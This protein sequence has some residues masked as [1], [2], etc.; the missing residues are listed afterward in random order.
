MGD[1]EPHVLALLALAGFLA[2][3]VDAVVGGGGLVQLPALLLGMPGASPAQVL[4]TNKF[5]SVWG[6]ATASVTYYRRVRPDLRT[7]LPMAAV[8]YVGAIGG[9]FI[10]LHIPKSLF[11]PVILVMLVLVGA[12]TLLKPS[13]G[14]L[15]R[16]RFSGARHTTAAVLTGFVIGVYDGALGPGTGSFLVF[17]LV[18]LLGYAFLE[19]SAK[20]KITNLATNLGALTVFAPGG[21][22]VWVVGGVMAVTNLVGGWVGARTAVAR[23]SRFVRTVFVV[24]VGAFVVRIGGDLAGL[25]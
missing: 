17:A 25:W 22:V 19:A 6:T 13:V 8:A 15:T 12:Y 5:S 14:E 1:I 21:H 9:A 7:A 20:A 3:W 24:V 18:G 11:N 10:G 2:G 23:G 4:A 16:L